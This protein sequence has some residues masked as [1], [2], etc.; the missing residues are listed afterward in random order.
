ML[1]LET[2]VL[3]FA[4]IIDSFTISVSFGLLEKKVTFIKHMNWIGWACALGQC[5]F[6]FI[7]YLVGGLLSNFIIGYAEW[8]GFLL[9]SGLSVYMLIDAM[10]QRSSA[11]PKQ[12]VFNFKLL[13][14]LI[15]ATSFDVLSV[16][17][18]LGLLQEQI[19]ILLIFLLIFTYISAYAGG[20]TGKIF[21]EKIGVYKGQIL[22]ALL[23][24]GLAV[25]L[26]F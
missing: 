4:L 24:F 26:L 6:L 15:F 23:I 1:L 18:T 7:G 5:F 12:K 9:L 17:L 13:I 19:G 2:V 14:F 10:K 11:A 8:I 25:S 3:A 16:G 22:G 21:G 20:Y